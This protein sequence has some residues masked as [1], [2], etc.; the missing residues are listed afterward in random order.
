[1]SAQLSWKLAKT[2][3]RLSLSFVALIVSFAVYAADSAPVALL[4]NELKALCTIDHSTAQKCAG[5]IAGVAD[6]LMILV[7]DTGKLPGKN[8]AFPNSNC[9]RKTSAIPLVELVALT[10]GVLDA[11]PKNLTEPA[12][13]VAEDTFIHRCGQAKSAQTA[14]TSVN[15]F[16]DGSRLKVMCA[17]SSADDRLQCVG[18]IRAVA[19]NTLILIK[20]PKVKVLGD[21]APVWR[22]PEQA[23]DLTIRY[24]DAHPKS[25][26]Q[27]APTVI[28]AALLPPSC[29]IAPI[30]SPP[31]G[32]R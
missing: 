2:R 5:Y 10:L 12:F 4:G 18:Y 1:M 16:A 29:P 15:V 11:E 17:S 7:R 32:A 28:R 27:A 20:N 25:L 6:E 23:V 21:C 3:L 8:P 9:I 26:P 31:A 24:L 19:D 14:I 22:T 13:A 30:V